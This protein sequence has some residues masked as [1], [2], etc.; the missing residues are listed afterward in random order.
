MTSPE[1]EAEASKIFQ[2]E[3]IEFED[4]RRFTFK[5][6]CFDGQFCSTY[7]ARL[8]ILKGIL[9]EKAKSKWGHLLKDGLGKQ[10]IVIGSLYKHQ[11]MKPS[12]LK[13]LSEELQ[14][15]P[16]PVR[17]SYYSS[18]DQLFIEDE[19]I[20]MKLVGN[21]INVEETIT[22]TICAILGH[23][24]DEGSFWVEDWCLPG[25]PAQAS[26]LS[27]APKCKGKILFLSGLDLNSSAACLA[28]NLLIEWTS[29]M[30]GNS[31][32][33]A[34][35]ASIVRVII[36]GNSVQ[37]SAAPRFSRGHDARKSQESV[38]HAESALA[39]NR[40]D[41]FLSHLLNCCP[42]TLMPGEFD[43]TNHMIPQQPLHPCI[44][45][46]SSRFKSL[47]GATN[48]WIGRIGSRIVA[49]SSGQPI[50]DIMKVANVTESS[51]LFWLERTLT[52]RHFSPT[53]PD[54]LSEYP[55]S[56]EDPLVIQECPD[57]YFTG[58]MDKYET[59]MY[60]G[61]EG[62]SVRSICIPKFSTT[63]TAVIVDLESL[64]ARP[65]SF[66]TS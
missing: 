58:N 50:N 35:Q 3:S 38:A 65:I 46:K 33:Q 63:Q 36:A 5:T 40:F 12:I 52:C 10:S 15:Y 7:T 55:Y 8:L 24:T 45:P 28:K 25:C 53:S 9:L 44:L 60:T 4:F 66:G 19:T 17:S 27:A 62:Q 39:S 18:K 57:I 59:R 11:E 20:R 34:Y 61:D 30:C 23:E 14:L 1:L 6:R 41:S 22:G 13:E 26:P 64:E 51:P 42:V 47:H 29:G 43:P 16:Q 21:H 32:T 37:G 48:P 49:G 56:G 31:R 54:T 2:R